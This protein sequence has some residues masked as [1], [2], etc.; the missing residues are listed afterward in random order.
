MLSIREASAGE[1]HL[2]AARGAVQI[3]ES[4]L[5]IKRNLHCAPIQAEI[6]QDMN[7]HP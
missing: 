2:P 4:S 3:N 5:A 6:A 7:R 1:K